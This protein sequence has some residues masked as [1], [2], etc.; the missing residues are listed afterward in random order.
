MIKIN[1]ADIIDNGGDYIVLSKL[2]GST[3]ELFTQKVDRIRYCNWQ[4]GMLIQEAF[5][6]NE[7]D[8]DYR[9]FILFPNWTPAEGDELFKNEE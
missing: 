5:P 2:C 7:F 1:P 4:N 6:P 3:N 8:A 9:N